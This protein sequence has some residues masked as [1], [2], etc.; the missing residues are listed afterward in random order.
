M[1]K[2]LP[3]FLNGQWQTGSGKGT[4]L[5]DPV[6]GTEL[7]RIDATGH[8]LGE[9]F[10]F[11][12]ESGGKQL[13]ALTYRERGQLLKDILTV[14]KENK[15]EYYEIS[16]ANSGTV[17]NDSAV[18]IEG[19]LFT[20][21]YYAKMGDTL[22]DKSYLLDGEALDLSRS[23]E[24]QSQHIFT[25]RPGLALFIN[26]FNFPCWGLWE[27][28]APALL[29]GVPVIVK[30]ASSTAWLTQR[31]VKDV[32]DSGILPV[33]SLSVICGSSAGLMDQLEAF[34]VVSFTGS[35]KTASIIR[36]H[37][38]IT[39]QSVRANIEAD[40]LNSALLLPEET[41]KSS[42]FELMVKEVCREMTV[43]SGQKCTAIRRIFVPEEM[44]DS[45]ATAISARL[46]RT[47]VGN[48][49][50]ESVRMGAIV[51]ST[52]YDDVVSGIETLKKCT[53]VLYDGSDCELISVETNHCC[54]AP[55]LLGTKTPDTNTLIHDVEVFGPVATLIPY[56]DIDH[57]MELIKRGKGSL[58]TSL[59]GDTNETLTALS[60]ELASYHGRVHVISTDIAAEQT[61]HGNVM[62]QSIHGGP[63]RAGGGQELGSERALHFYHQCSAIQASH[64]V[65][66]HL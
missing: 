23:S 65:L 45:T 26:A 39:E 31:M 61:G 66:E 14:L 63:G 64:S 10:Q 51:N 42:A 36:S 3:N 35:A 19:G 54:L 1:S 59:Y 55:T 15:N 62:P 22:G 50:D 11:A 49:R 12:R 40:S 52:Q 53:D 16:T 25:S 41:V 27:K 30:P 43:K 37:P 32:I 13:K 18:D 48:P 24:F 58:V 21:G 46:A 7:V 60:I 34:D 44:Y 6:L 17:K 4:S 56:R 2:L 57:A 20:L 47:I 28:A 8:D 29:S 9:A 33:G 5:Y 38:A